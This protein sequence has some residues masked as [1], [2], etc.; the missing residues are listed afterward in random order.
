MADQ[1]FRR[2]SC[3][4]PIVGA[5]SF[6]TPASA[7]PTAADRWRPRQLLRWAV[8][9]AACSVFAGATMAAAPGLDRSAG[10]AGWL[11]Q[12]VP[13]TNPAPGTQPPP[14]GQ[15]PGAQ[16][17]GGQAPGTQAPGTQAPGAQ[18]PGGAATAV[19]SGQGP[20]G[21]TP[22]MVV[23]PATDTIAFSMN[24]SNGMEMAEFIK[25]AQE[26]T[27]RR[28]TFSINDL[29]TGGAGGNTVSF[30]GTFRIKRSRFTEDFY[31]FFQTML[32]I[33]GFA[34]VPR[35]EGDLEILEIVAMGGARAR[36]VTNGAK[37]VTP[38]ELPQYRN[39]T[40]VPILTTVPL[41]N[42]NA[43]I[44]TNALRPFFASTGAPTGGG[45]LTLGNVGNNSAML[46]QGF[47]PQVFA[48]VELLKLVDVPVEQ[49]NLVVQVIVLD[50]Q[51]PE[52]LEP[53]LT[54]VLESRSRIRQQVMQ[55][56]NAG[57]AGAVAGASGQPQLKVVV[58]SSQRALVLSGTQEQ[59]R[60][61]LDLVARLDVPG[62]VLDGQASVINLRNV[63]AKDLRETLNQF[64]QEDNNAEQQ[65]ASAGGGAAGGAGAAAARRQRR[66]T[67]RATRWWCRRP[68][69]SGS[70]SRT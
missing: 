69:P 43:T 45:T 52:E 67:R 10:A 39:Q 24:E 50:H 35:G 22:S 51:A 4:R 28:F 30:L 32:Y 33:K 19:D 11:P 64:L 26:V 48:A 34:V 44:A 37:Y 14:A 12:E 55:E 6:V 27:G 53:I 40:G 17:P 3:P 20:Q 1:V 68:A 47:G 5:G 16:A 18:G 9:L 29:Q 65:A 57:G 41:K 15:A 7:A 62:Q 56:N 42:I 46:L 54:D 23:D 8:R 70:R 61:A 59:V 36:E 2:S 21:P 49:P 60:E 58:H 31:S 38:D 25:W 66:T 63:L 13:A